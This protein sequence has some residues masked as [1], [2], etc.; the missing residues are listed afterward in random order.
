[1]QLQGRQ[2]AGQGRAGQDT[3]D[4]PRCWASW[5]LESWE[6][7]SSRLSGQRSGDS[8]LS[9][10]PRCLRAANPTAGARQ[11]NIHDNDDDYDLN[12][13]LN[14]DLDYDL[15]YD[16]R[17]LPVLVTAWAYAQRL[18]LGFAGNANPGPSKTW[19]IDGRL[20]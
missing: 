4:R 16:Y 11:C 10:R 15:N 18:V 6:G 3:Q 14:Y 2:R 20:Y 1:V 7:G 13:D 5:A 9:R 12:Y 17:V 19:S 8:P